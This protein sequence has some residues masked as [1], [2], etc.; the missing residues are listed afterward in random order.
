MI[1]A[2]AQDAPDIE[3]FNKQLR[4]LQD[5]FEL[6]QRQLRE[7]F[8][9]QQSELRESF[10]KMMREQQAQ[11][12]TLKKQLAN[13]TNAVAGMLQTNQPPP[14]PQLKEMEQKVNQV[15]EAQKT[16][17]PNEFNPSIGFVSESIFSYTTKNGITDRP[18]GFDFFQRTMELDIA[19]SVDPFASG[20]AVINAQADP[21]TGEASVGVE[22]AAIQTISLPWNLQLKAGRFFGEFGRLSYIH[23]HELP[24]VNRPLVLDEYVGGESQTDGAQ[25][26]WL[27]PLKHYVNVTLGLGDKFGDDPN[28]PGNYRAFNQLDFWS[29]VSTY[30]DLSPNWQ[31]ETGLSG[32]WGPNADAG[33]PP[34][35][36]PDGSTFALR[37]RRLVDLDFRLSWVPL[38]NNEFQNLVWGNEVLY[39]D[40]NYLFNPDGIPS[41]GNE[42]ANT[43]GSLGLY[44]YLTY[45]WSRQWSGGFLFNWVEAPQNNGIRTFQY[46]PY[47][48]WAISHWNQ[49][50]LQYTHTQNS[51]G[52]GLPSSDAVYL[53]WAWIIGSHSHGWQAR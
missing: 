41:S 43:I 36:E 7:N 24:F 12:E 32:L 39:S 4:E 31:L 17:R 25:L 22:E 48:T 16:V 8:E 51:S 28:Y 29:R 34:V 33:Q 13:T 37:E 50:R 14:S 5:R 52:S 21:T 44:S 53:Q 2:H 49:L 42:F 6:Q 23:D 18:T 10:E 11:I 35:S 30:F 9:K 1:M 3:K 40:N 15:V 47:I 45:R 20:Y 19:A 26:N 46:S 27:T 38:Q